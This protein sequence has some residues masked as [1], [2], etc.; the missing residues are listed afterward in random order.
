[1][2]GDVSY[3]NWDGDAAASTSALAAPIYFRKMY[4]GFFLEPAITFKALSTDFNGGTENATVVGPQ[5]S[6]GW[7]WYWDSGLNLQLSLGIGR[8]WNSNDCEAFERA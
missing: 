3:Y 6:A 8:N 1:M 7:H 4:S 2:R 5:M